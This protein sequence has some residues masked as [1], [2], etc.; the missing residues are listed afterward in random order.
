METFFFII[1]GIIG[2]AI[3]AKLSQP[4][5]PNRRQQYRQEAWQKFA[6]DCELKLKSKNIFNEDI[7]ARGIYRGYNLE[8]F[9][10]TR[11]IPGKHPNRKISRTYTNLK[12]GNP[13]FTLQ[14][15]EAQLAVWD[16]VFLESRLLE[17]RDDL[18]GA[19]I[20]KGLIHHARRQAYLGFKE[21]LIHY[22]YKEFEAKSKYLKRLADM[23]ADMADNI[24]KVI[25]LGGE[26]VPILQKMVD[27]KDKFAGL[28]VYLLQEIAAQSALL[29]PDEGDL[30]CPHCL[31]HYRTLPIKLPWQV[32]PMYYA[33]P[34]CHQNRTYFEGEVVAVLNEGMAENRVQRENQLLLNWFAHKVLFDFNAIHI[35]RATDKDVEQFVVAIGN[36]TDEER[37]G[38]YDK[39]RCTIATDCNLSENTRRVLAEVD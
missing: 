38:R 15:R 2:A 22:Q 3:A 20:P 33:C 32:D 27:E 8:V 5:E 30:F 9:T 6:K 12:F 1:L 14:E 26:V 13:D 29:K 24:P 34:Q 31:L 36:D 11:H 25:C 19:L 4:V 16:N 7:R 10:S 21:G 37:R 39:M 17:T 28:A 35:Q 23:L 18:I